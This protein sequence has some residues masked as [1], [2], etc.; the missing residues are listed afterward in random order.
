M[1]HLPPAYAPY[2][3][4]VLS[5]HEMNSIGAS[6]IPQPDSNVLFVLVSKLLV[7]ISSTNCDLLYHISCTYVTAKYRDIDTNG[8]WTAQ[9][10]MLCAGFL[11][12]S[13]VVANNVIVIQCISSVALAVSSAH[14]Y[15]SVV[16]L[17]IVSCPVKR[18][19]VFVVESVNIAFCLLTSTHFHV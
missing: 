16:R 2:F 18:W 1:C 4:N 3:E 11:D 10:D 5:P 6:S 15:H 13:V 9:S 19:I 17:T 7:D 14:S 8:Y 12:H